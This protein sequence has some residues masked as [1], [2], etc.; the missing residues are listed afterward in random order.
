[1]TSENICEYKINLQHI[2]ANKCYATSISGMQCS[3]LRV[4][5]KSMIGLFV[6]QMWIRKCEG[7]KCLAHCLV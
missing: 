5:E 4:N 1:M 3:C 6:R 2:V 7:P